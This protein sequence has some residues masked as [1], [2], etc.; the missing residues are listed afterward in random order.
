MRSISTLKSVKILNDKKKR[1]CEGKNK[2][3]DACIVKLFIMPNLLLFI[4]KINYLF[5]LFIVF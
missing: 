3:F 1:K 4:I 5:N 2:T